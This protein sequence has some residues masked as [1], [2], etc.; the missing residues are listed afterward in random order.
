MSITNMWMDE[1]YDP[2][3]DRAHWMLKFL[4]WPQRSELTGQWI[5]LCRAYQGTA[6]WT[7]VQG[8]I[9]VVEIRYHRSVE[10]VIWKL[11]GN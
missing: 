4:W 10:H 1:T 2:F 6:I 7:G 11:K 9:P 3:K 8:D 5:W